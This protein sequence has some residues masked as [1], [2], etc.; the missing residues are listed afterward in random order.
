MNVLKKL[1][2]KT[3]DDLKLYTQPELSN[4]AGIDQ[5]TANNWILRSV[6]SPWRYGRASGRGPRLF[7]GTE[8]FRAR[9]INELVHSLGMTPLKAAG[10]LERDVFL[11]TVLACIAA[12]RLEY[13]VFMIITL[14][15]PE[16]KI[17]LR[18]PGEGIFYKYS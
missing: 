17:C 10:T 18:K 1:M 8:I 4:I 9:I 7:L 3:S 2:V 11:E 16:G 14:S 5:I 6:L 12:I 15:E 13:E